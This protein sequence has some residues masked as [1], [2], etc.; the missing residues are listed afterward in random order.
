MK[1]AIKKPRVKPAPK[2]PQLACGPLEYIRTKP[3]KGIDV[4]RGYAIGPKGRGI[5]IAQVH[6]SASQ[7]EETQEAFAKL[8]T[9][10]PE[11]AEACLWAMKMGT[12]DHPQGRRELVEF[13]RQAL[14]KAGLLG[15]D[16]APSLLT[17]YVEQVR[18]L[19][20]FARFAEKQADHMAERLADP[21]EKNLSP[22]SVISIYRHIAESARMTLAKIER[23]AE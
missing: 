4:M 17:N 7:N 15:T 3:I 1:K 21:D 2:K 5:D 10:A 12:T 9:A 20:Q 6:L 8:F 22:E 18:E 13:S 14:D 23:S 16:H 19:S 11:L